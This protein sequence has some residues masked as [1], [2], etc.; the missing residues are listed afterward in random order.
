MGGVFENPTIRT[1]GNTLQGLAENGAEAIV[2]LENNLKWLD[3]LAGM[4]NER[5][6]SDKPIILNVDGKVF[7]QTSINSINQL[8]RQT[9][10]LGLNIV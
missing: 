1:F 8:T 2:P 5:M 10:H 4:L 9:G 6:G 7:A 3:K